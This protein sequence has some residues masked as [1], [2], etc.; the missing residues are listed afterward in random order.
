MAFKEYGDHDALGLAGLVRSKQVSPRELLD[1][2]VA[3]TER[4]NPRINAVVVRHEDYAQRQ[5]D[6]G[7]PDGPFTG[8]P[9]LLKDL[10]LLDGTRTT[11]GASL[12]KDF[13]ADHTGTLAQRFLK[14]GLT[15]I[16]QEREPRI[17]ADADDR[18]PAA[19]TDAQSLEYRSCIRRLVRRRSR[20]RGCAHPAGRPCQRRRRFDPYSSLGLRR[21]RSEADPRS[22]SDGS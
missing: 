5:I 8:V 9:F 7:L 22:Q 6:E 10:E 2:A 12:Y 21:V 3:R 20:C 16:R 19:W 1:E 14:A 18:M 15:S 4:V 11:F 17:R 13:V